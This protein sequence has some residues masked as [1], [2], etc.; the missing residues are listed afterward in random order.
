MTLLHTIEA[1]CPPEHFAQQFIQQNIQKISQIFFSL[2]QPQ[3]FSK[4]EIDPTGQNIIGYRGQETVSAERMSTGQ[5][6]ALVLSVFFQMNLT[7]GSVPAFL[8]LD[9][10]VANIDDLNVLALIDFLR[11]FVIT[12]HR[13]IVVT[14]ANRN[15]AK[16]FRRKLSF[17]LQDFQ[18]LS[19]QREQEMQLQITKRCYSQQTVLYEQKL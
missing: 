4:L 10:P 11:E 9:E 7:A 17:L 16:L 8:L 1:L 18:E 5:R 3:E 13:Q 15:V 12:H 2:H 19:F 6:T 14:T